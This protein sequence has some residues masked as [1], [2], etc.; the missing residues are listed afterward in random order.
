VRAALPS[1]V[2]QSLPAT[3]AFVAAATP[4]ERAGAADEPQPASAATSVAARRA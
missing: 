2:G 1:K 3:T 4:F